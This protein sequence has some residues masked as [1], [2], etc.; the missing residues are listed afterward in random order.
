MTSCVVWLHEEAL[1]REHPV[2]SEAPS[3][4]R[5][6]FTWDDDYLRQMNYS[7]KRLLF[8]YETLCGL[9]VEIIRG[10]A[11]AILREISPSRI[12]VPATSKPHIAATIARLESVATVTVVEDEPFVL[13]DAGYDFKRFFSY[14]KRVEKKATNPDQS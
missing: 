2:F 1:R 13:L 4:A 3:D 5:F 11:A 9:P 10:E 7:F 14:W 8:I 6:V 12:L